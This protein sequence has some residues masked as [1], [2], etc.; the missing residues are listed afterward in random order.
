MVSKIR[1]NALPKMKD[2]N[3]KQKILFIVTLL[4]AL[5]LTFLTD[6]VIVFFIFLGMVLF[7]VLRALYYLI[8]GSKDEIENE[9]K[10][11]EN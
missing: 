11:S 10:V 1:Y 2:K 6:G 8:A 3:F 5:V 4:V 7:G 9:I